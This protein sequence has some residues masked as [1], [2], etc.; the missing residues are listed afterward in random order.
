MYFQLGIEQIF[1]KLRRFLCTVM[2]T[3]AVCVWGQ[4]FQSQLSLSCRH[5]VYHLLQLFAFLGDQCPLKP[6]LPGMRADIHFLPSWPV[7][8]NDY[9]KSL[10]PPLINSPVLL[11][12]HPSCP[13]GLPCQTINPL[14]QDLCHVTGHKAQGWLGEGKESKFLRLVPMPPPGSCSLT[15]GT[16]LPGMLLPQ[17]VGPSG[18][19]SSWDLWGEAP[20]GQ[21][22]TGNWEQCGLVGRLMTSRDYGPD[23]PAL[24]DPCERA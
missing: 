22:L 5:A 17:V 15:I 12:Y 2:V 10:L 18:G 16:P 24:I 19:N 9:D 23:S 14:R 8:L 13:D 6:L 4:M 20:A 11:L 3:P 21:G 1:S 7:F